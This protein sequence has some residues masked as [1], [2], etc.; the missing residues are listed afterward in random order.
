LVQCQT[1]NIITPTEFDNIKI[2]GITLKSIR[3]TLGNQNEVETLFGIAYN[4][5]KD[6]DPIY[7]G[8]IFSIDYYYNGFECG[9]YEKELSSFE[10]TNNNFN[11]TI[12]GKTI[13][14]GDNINILGYVI[15]N[16][17]NDNKKSIV[18]MYCEGCNNYISV[19]FD[20]TTKIITEIYYIEQT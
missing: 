20:Q 15:F 1:A 13:T 12:K 5:I 16:T 11:I 2:N 8:E 17:M 7:G 19:R 10:I 18:Y 9:F 14:I 3:N 4:T 6:D